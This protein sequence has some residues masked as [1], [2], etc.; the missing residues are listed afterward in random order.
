MTRVLAVLSLAIAV[1]FGATGCKEKG[2]AEKAGEQVDKA[3]S[4][5]GDSLKDAAEDVKGK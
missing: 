1:T 4:D 3:V 2:E 5:I